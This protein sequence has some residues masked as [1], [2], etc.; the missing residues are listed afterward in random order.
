MHS[1]INK[2]GSAAVIAVVVI[3]IIIAGIIW[4]KTVEDR[5]CKRDSDCGQESYCGADF[6]CHKI[7]VIEKTVIT[8][9]YNFTAAA[10]ILAIAIIIAAIILR[11]KMN[12]KKED[13]KEQKQELYD[14]LKP[15]NLSEEFKK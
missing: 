5:E 12:G 14:G 10:I 3:V 13:K 2:R 11:W 7:P 1:K 8:N 6:S 9:E 15:Y 4:A